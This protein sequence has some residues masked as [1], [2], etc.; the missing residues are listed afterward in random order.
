MLCVIITH[1][2]GIFCL[3]YNVK[4]SKE[5]AIFDWKVQKQALFQ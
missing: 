1:Y 5:T 2:L 4:K 3:S